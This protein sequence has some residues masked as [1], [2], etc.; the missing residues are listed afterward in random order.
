[1]SIK[2]PLLHDYFVARKYEFTPF[3]P[4]ASS[5][6]STRSP[7]QNILPLVDDRGFLI[8]LIPEAHRLYREA[9]HFGMCGYPNTLFEIELSTP[10]PDFMEFT[11]NVKEAAYQKIRCSLRTFRQRHRDGSEYILYVLM[12]PDL[13]EELFDDGSLPD[14]RGVFR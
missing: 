13:C 6:S 9:C 11:E 14:L 1:M 2:Q 8:T 4:V 3:G 5:M 10:M 12:T 7:S